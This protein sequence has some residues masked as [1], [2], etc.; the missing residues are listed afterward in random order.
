MLIRLVNKGPTVNDKFSRLRNA[1]QII[2]ADTSSGHHSL[3]LDKN[4]LSQ[5]LLPANGR[6]RYMILP[7]S[8]A[9]AGDMV[10]HK[11]DEIFKELPNIFDI[12]NN[13]SIAG[14]NDDDK[15]HDRTL[16]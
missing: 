8:T 15:E 14:Y 16:R 13:I 7:F 5:Q 6:H 4:L 2:L 1:C 11:T 9:P 10:H 12:A 3:K